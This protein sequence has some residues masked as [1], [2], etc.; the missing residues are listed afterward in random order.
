MMY[1]LFLMI[2]ILVIETFY[3]L[4][5]GISETLNKLV[6]IT[7]GAAAVVGVCA[8]LSASKLDPPE[9]YTLEETQ[10]ALDHVIDKK[11]RWLKP[12]QVNRP[13]LADAFFEAQNRFELPSL[14]L[15]SIGYYESKYLLDAVGDG[16]RS[17]GIMQVGVKGRRRCREYCGNMKT[18]HE[19]ILCG[20]CW[21][22]ENIDWCKT[23]ERGLTGYA[24]G[25]CRSYYARTKNAVQ[26]RFRLWY[27]L[28]DRV[29]VNNN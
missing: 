18:E 1:I 26:R 21:L 25:R 4:V 28:H 19:Q 15:I 13:A 5:F 12:E 6:K 2:G 14:V 27:D 20:G 24:C 11:I 23:F 29:K 7:I 3:A 8:L 9:R 17:V 10:E 16:G 22:R